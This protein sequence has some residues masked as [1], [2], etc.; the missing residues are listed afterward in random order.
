[1]RRG[2]P[3][4]GGGPS[5]G[6]W[7]SCSCL[8]WSTRH[9]GV[10]V[11]GGDH[12]LRTSAPNHQKIHG[13]TQSLLPRSDL[14]SSVEYCVGIGV[15][16]T[17]AAAPL[18]AHQDSPSAAPPGQSLSVISE[19]HPRPCVAPSAYWHSA[20]TGLRRPASGSI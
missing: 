1:M 16:L 2:S 10:P 19:L 12:G 14:A 8:A 18:G 11:V 17:G 3:K 15:F 4:E 9:C 5:C 20:R 13:R 6:C 7:A